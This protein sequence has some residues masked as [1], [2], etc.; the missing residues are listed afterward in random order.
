M[1][2]NKQADNYIDK[3]ENPEAGRSA[4]HAKNE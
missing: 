1:D 3:Y 2:W 4:S